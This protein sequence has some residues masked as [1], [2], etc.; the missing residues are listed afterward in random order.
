MLECFLYNNYFLKVMKMLLE[1]ELKWTTNN[2]LNIRIKSNHSTFVIIHAF[3]YTRIHFLLQNAKKNIL[4][5]KV[6]LYSY[7][8]IKLFSYILQLKI[9]LL[10]FFVIILA[11]NQSFLFCEYCNFCVTFLQKSK[12]FIFVRQILNFLRELMLLQS[13]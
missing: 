4:T 13:I 7:Q 5:F 12:L 11:T 2:L 6:S 8:T 10:I 9:W 3:E 1:S